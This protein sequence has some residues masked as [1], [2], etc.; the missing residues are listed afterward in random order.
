MADVKRPGGAATK[1]ALP[2]PATASATAAPHGLGD[3]DDVLTKAI[4]ARQVLQSPRD[5]LSCYTERHADSY[6]RVKI[7]TA[8]PNSLTLE[9]TIFTACRQTNILALNTSPSSSSSS[10]STP[11]D[12]HL[13]PISRVQTFNIIST[14][15]AT[16]T[17]I[18]DAQPPL[19]RI[20]LRALK[21]KEEA[22]IRKIREKDATRGKGVSKEGQEI[23][24][25]IHRTY[26]LSLLD[27]V[28]SGPICCALFM[29]MTHEIS[30]CDHEQS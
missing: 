16:S 30:K 2:K 29:L 6:T 22:A 28:L 25:A 17:G 8:S 18:E 10:T 4:G 3:L 11:S 19:S 9:G 13:I 24:D 23:F 26:V 5:L 12:Y 14:P 7:T 20:D 15:L 1:P 27:P 21:A